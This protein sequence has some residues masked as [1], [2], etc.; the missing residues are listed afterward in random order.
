MST[1]YLNRGESIILTT[2]RVSV[3]S[4]LFDMMLTNERL[5]LIDSRYTRFEPRMIF[6]PAITTVKGGKI[7]T[8]EPAIVLT[9]EE[10]SDLSGSEQVNLIFNQQPEEQRKHERDLW[11]KKIIELVIIAREHAVRK[12]TVPARKKT[13]IQPSVRRWE[14]PE[15]LRPHSSVIAPIPPPPAIIVTSEEPDSPELVP[16][17]RPVEEPQ[18]PEEKR[19]GVPA[20]E[21]VPAPGAPAFALEEESKIPEPDIL[22]EAQPEEPLPPLH[23]VPAGEELTLPEG[24]INPEPCI[25]LGNT[26]AE[27]LSAAI[28]ETPAVSQPVDETGSSVPFSSTVLAAVQSLK[29]QTASQ[30][31]DVDISFLPDTSESAQIA[32]AEIQEPDLTLSETLKISQNHGFTTPAPVP[33]AEQHVVPHML[34]NSPLP[35]QSKELPK[36]SAPDIQKNTQPSRAE[37]PVIITGALILIALIGMFG[38]IY[39]LSQYPLDHSGDNPA[40][41]ITPAITVRQTIPPAPV[42]VPQTGIRV[43]VIYPGTFTGTVGNPGLLHQVS[44]TGNRTFSILMTTSIIQ[45]T[46]QKQDNSGDALTVEIYDNSTLLSHKTITAPMGEINLLIDTETGRPP[47]MTNDTIPGGSGPLIYY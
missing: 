21:I 20:P 18:P 31:P 8:G 6:F 47:G 25:V 23:E 28:P 24:M 22:P 34:Q 33:D 44:S 29:S 41:T 45:A 2:H 38:G 9:L 32:V 16:K 36:P 27:S 43:N 19:P 30:Q 14:A 26:S 5:I 1:P 15:P 4:V 11:I 12:N 40:V 42:T 39:L 7:S 46:I 35:G 37:R 13:G 3:S 17:E 10:P